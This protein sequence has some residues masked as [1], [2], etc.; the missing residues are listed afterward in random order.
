MIINH[1]YDFVFVH[2]PKA[3]GTSLTHAL[4]PLSHY[5][6]Q[7]IGSTY[8]GQKASEYY[9]KRYALRKHSTVDDIREVM[10]EAEWSRYFKFAFVRNP[11]DRLLSAYH[12]LKGWKGLPNHHQERIDYYRS[13]QDFVDSG[14]WAE[15]AGPDNIFKPQTN[16]VCDRNT[17]EIAVDF[18]G[19]TE[20]IK[21][22]L[23]TI[24]RKLN[25]T[26]TIG[27]A[28]TRNESQKTPGRIVWTDDVLALFH[29][30]YGKDIELF[31]YANS[32]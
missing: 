28:E 13:A 29:Q 27:E 16:W 6:D 2:I 18:L 11:F 8:W 12:F 20:N 9:A 21:A 4:S 7:E 26:H 24:G 32:P 15:W 30:R 25:V 5:R 14:V 23:Q 22:D 17:S 1:T 3:A 19:R 10:S 31:G